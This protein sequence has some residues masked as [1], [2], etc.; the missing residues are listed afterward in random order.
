VLFDFSFATFIR[1]LI[2]ISRAMKRVMTVK[3]IGK[4]RFY[5]FYIWLPH[6]TANCF[7]CLSLFFRKRRQ[8]EFFYRII[9]SF[10]RS[11]IG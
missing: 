7:Y 9:A 3:S 11:Y 5:P 2:Q 6:V 8:A 1:C 10:L 4:P